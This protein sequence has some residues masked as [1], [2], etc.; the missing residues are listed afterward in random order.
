MNAPLKRHPILQ[1]EWIRADG[2]RQVESRVYCDVRRRSVPV[3]TCRDCLFCVATEGSEVQCAPSPDLL[4]AD[5]PSAGAALSRGAVV[6]DSGVLVGNVVNLFVEKRLRMLVVADASGRAQ[7]VVHES[8]LLSQIR[9]ATHIAPYSVTLG[10]DE[11]AIE[12][13]SSVTSTPPTVD[14]SLPL[15]EALM[16]MASAHQRQ[17]L[18][19]DGQGFPIGLLWDVDA[20]HRLKTMQSDDDDG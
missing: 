6:V 15:R 20:L 3:D 9:D 10:W 11:A 18:V 5:G 17:L 16:R 8:R 14:E 1:A 7:G 19:V 13:A 2:A 12:P 4:T